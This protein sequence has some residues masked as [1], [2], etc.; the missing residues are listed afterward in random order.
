MLRKQHGGTRE[1]GGDRPVGKVISAKT[2][3]VREE[4]G[5]CLGVGLYMCGG[6]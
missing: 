4:G 1:A 5:R 3:I 6:L 2:V